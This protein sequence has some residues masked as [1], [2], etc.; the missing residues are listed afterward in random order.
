MGV[1]IMSDDVKKIIYLIDDDD[2]QLTTSELFLQ[3][4]YEI[5]KSKSGQEALDYINS[6][7]LI[8]DL[9]LLDILM[10]DMDGWEV[11]RKMKEMDL[12]K[13]VPIVFLTS[14][15]AEVERKRAYNIGIT[16]YI[17]KPYNMTELKSRVKNIIKNQQPRPEG[18][19][20]W[21]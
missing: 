10:P 1:A 20:M 9:V 3:D 4:E 17:V 21:F 7:E 12:L 14:V 6:N 13:K 5:Y 8:P 15:E 11:F 16:D 2:M 18:R 19:G